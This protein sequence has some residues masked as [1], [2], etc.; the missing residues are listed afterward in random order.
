MK[1]IAKTDSRINRTAYGPIG[2]L[3]GIPLAAVGVYFAGGGFGFLPLPGK[4]NAPLWVIGT[5]GLCFFFMGLI[6][7]VQVM[8]S[9]LH[10][11][12]ATAMRRQFPD[13]PWL[14]DYPWD[15]AGIRDEAGSRAAGS[16]MAALFLGAF[17]VPFNWWAFFTPDP[18]LM[19]KGI[20]GIFDVVWLLSVGTMAYRLLQ[21]A[22]YGYSRLIFPVF[23]FVPGERLR[24]MFT[25]NRF[26]RLRATLRY[27]EERFESERIANERSVRQVSDE[28]YADEHIYNVAETDR[29]V[30]LEFDLPDNPAW[31]TRM[32]A[33][34]SIRYWELVVASDVAGVDFRTTFPLPV[35]A[36]TPSKRKAN[37]AFGSFD[38]RR[39]QPSG[40]RPALGLAAVLGL[41][42][43][44][45]IIIDPDLH[46]KVM[47]WVQ[48]VWYRLGV[49]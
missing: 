10:Q 35:Y 44:A 38:D 14:A 24:V 5:I 33:N 41:L 46:G 21:F 42:L 36:A 20:T 2:L 48:S 19:V 26:A 6:I 1:R 32:T 39:Q 27:V 12:R 28:Y 25:P 23:P 9:I 40:Y 31:T 7:V 34:P 47:G 4:A 8:R 13:R 30:L 43:A 37:P 18:G 17:L 49:P 16:F 11:R 3:L 22:R 15:T 29:R 45:A